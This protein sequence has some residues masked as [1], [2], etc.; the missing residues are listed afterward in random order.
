MYPDDSTLGRG[1]L[2]WYQ[3]DLTSSRHLKETPI[4]RFICR[5]MLLH[6]VGT[7]T[8]R[9]FHHTFGPHPQTFTKRRFS[10]IPFI[11]GE[12]GIAWGVL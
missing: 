1:G 2:N 6:L 9:L 10:G 7:I 11:V 8:L 4:G 5:I 3:N 12:R